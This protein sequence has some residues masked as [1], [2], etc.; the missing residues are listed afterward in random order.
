MQDAKQKLLLYEGLKEEVRYYYNIL[1]R[2]EGNESMSTIEEDGGGRETYE[3]ER[4]NETKR[5]K[6]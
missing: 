1:R 5:K 4:E 6:D 3:R 2:A